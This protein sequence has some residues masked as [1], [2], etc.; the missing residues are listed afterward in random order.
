VVVIMTLDHVRDFFHAYSM[1]ASPTDLSR[2]NFAI[3]FTRWLTHFCAPTFLFL[4]G[5]SAFLWQRSRGSA[6]RA[7]RYLLSRGALLVVLELTLMRW[8]FDFRF[9]SNY[10]VLLITLWA[11]GVSMILLAGLLHLP[12]RIL[13]P[14]SAAVILLHNLLDPLNL[15]ASLWNLLHQPGIFNVGGVTVLAGYPL[16]PLFAVMALGYCAGH[17]YTLAP[18]DR[19]RK[20]WR[21][22]A[23]AT[24]GFVLLR[25]VNMYGDPAP[26]ST[27]RDMLMTVASFLN[28]TKQPASLAFLLMTLGPALLMLA[29]LEARPVGPRNPLLVYGRESLFYFIAHFHLAHWLCVLAMVWQYGAAAPFLWLPV[30]AVGGPRAA[31]PAQFGYSLGVTYVLWIAV[32]V[33]MYPACRWWAARPS[34]KT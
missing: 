11:L 26:W 4:A 19:L 18:A 27:Q 28:A 32:T 31:F 15:N 23:A 21:T 33:L 8:A 20:L 5:I 2:A 24:L 13:A 16:I 12:L 7:S 17:W 9:F 1:D 25:A 34:V 3:F 29:A 22:G 14:A 6:P 10:P 30:P